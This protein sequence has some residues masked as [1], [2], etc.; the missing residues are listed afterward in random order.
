[1]AKHLPADC[2][3]I[4]WSLGGLIAQQIACAFPEKLKQLIL[5]CCSPKF[6]KSDDWPGIEPQILSLFLRQ[7]DMSFSK[8]LARFLAIQAI[9]SE[10]I[11]SDIKT[12]KQAIEQHPEP[13]NSALVAGLN[14]LQQVDLREQ[15]IK[16]RIPCYVFLGRLDTLVPHNL[17]LCLQELAPQIKIEV[18]SKAAHAPFISDTKEFAKRLSDIVI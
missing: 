12:I 1:V 4:G 15:L 17:A 13:A 2:V 6:S 16:L 3:V 8:T 10:S 11:K 14:M 5:I 9:G 18:L 7:L